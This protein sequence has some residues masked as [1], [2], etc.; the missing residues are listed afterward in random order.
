MVFFGKL[1]ARSNNNEIM[2][3]TGKELSW[4]VCPYGRKLLCCVHSRYWTGSGLSSVTSVTSKW[5]DYYSLLQGALNYHQ[6]ALLSLYPSLSFPQATHST[7][8]PLLIH[9]RWKVYVLYVQ[10]QTMCFCVTLAVRVKN[11]NS[12]S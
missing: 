8:Y 2:F 5:R 9:G 7:H 12:F 1:N 4:L 10:K 3:L 6:G 11:Q